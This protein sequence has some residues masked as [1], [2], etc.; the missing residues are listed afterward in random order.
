MR[1]KQAV[2][3][4][5]SELLAILSVFVPFIIATLKL[6]WDRLSEQNSRLREANKIL[7]KI[8]NN[9]ILRGVTPPSAELTIL[10]QRIARKYGIKVT[11]LDDIATSLCNGYI[12]FMSNHI[13]T[14]QFQY[15][16][17]TYGSTFEEDWTENKFSGKELLQDGYVTALFLFTVFS[18]NGL[19]K[20]MNMNQEDYFI[21]LMFTM[22]LSILIHFPLQLFF[23]K[24]NEKA[25]KEKSSASRK[26]IDSLCR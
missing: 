16:F 5:S 15:N 18:I 25:R 10:K 2:S 24:L 11:E 13:Q 26:E 1:Y 12:I 17:K 22:I 20:G 9:Y 6:Y 7:S 8:L 19:Y 3:M 14:T 21:L 23:N 4:T